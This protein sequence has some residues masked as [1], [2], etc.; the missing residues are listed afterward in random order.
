MA[1]RSTEAVALASADFMAVIA[2]RAYFK[3]LHRGFVPGHEIEDWLAAERE[4][5]ELARSAVPVTAKKKPAV[6]RKAGML[7]TSQK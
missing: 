4:V 7:K 6:R 3:A 5:A 1:R 2:E